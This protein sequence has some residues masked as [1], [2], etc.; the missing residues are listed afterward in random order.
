MA[1]GHLCEFMD[2]QK[3]HKLRK[4]HSFQSILVSPL[5]LQL[6]MA[7]QFV[8]DFTQFISCPGD[9]LSSINDPGY[10]PFLNRRIL[11]YFSSSYNRFD[12]LVSLLT[13]Q[14]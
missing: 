2:R 3:T 12:R 5:L 9:Q 8:Q 10:L 11:F 6:S 1:A 13:H 4:S 7:G 14:L